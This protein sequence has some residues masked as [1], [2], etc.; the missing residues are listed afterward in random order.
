M[1]TWLFLFCC[2]H[3]LFEIL[4]M[5][6]IGSCFKAEGRIS[7]KFD[8][9]YFVS[10]KMGSEVLNGV[11]YH[12]NQQA[13]PSSSKSGAQSC[14]AIVPYYSPP[15]SGRRNRRRRNGDPNRPKPNRSGYN[16]FFAEKHAMLKSL[17]PHREREFT[18]MIG[19]SWN[20]LS[21]EEKM[22]S[23]FKLDHIVLFCIMK[24]HHKSRTWALDVTWKINIHVGDPNLLVIKAHMQYS[25]LSVH[26]V[27]KKYFF[28]FHV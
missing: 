26:S 20:N 19:E 16:F 28:I 22:V 4:F 14:N 5:C 13:Q 7:A 23:L 25:P 12:P 10:L 17:H 27:L 8:C 24:I 15:I 11:L 3:C 1:C 6:N 21:P 2:S 18:K 9:G